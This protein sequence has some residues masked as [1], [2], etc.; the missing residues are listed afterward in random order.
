MLVHLRSRCL[1]TAVRAPFSQDSSMLAWS[2]DRLRKFGGSVKRLCRRLHQCRLCGAPPDPYVRRPRHVAA[3]RELRA[4]GPAR[5]ARIFYPLHV[6]LCDV[7]PARAA[8]RVRARRGH[9]LRL[10]LLLVVLRLLGRAREAV[11]RGDDRAARPDAGQPGHRGRQ[12]R[13]LPAAALRGR[14]HPG[15]RRRAGRERGRGRP[16]PRA[17]RPRSSSSAPETGREIARRHGRADLVAANNV[18]AHVPDIRGFAAGPARAG[19][20]R[21]AWSRWSSRTCC[22]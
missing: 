11:R 8:S 1:S 5:R 2:S 22:G 19:Q 16:G 14:G 9:L 15:A 17:S 21:R 13:R 18:F 12:Q 4:R 20:G 6:R 3:V 7:M 10:R